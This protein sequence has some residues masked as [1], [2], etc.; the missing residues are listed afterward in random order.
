VGTRDAGREQM[1]RSRYKIV[2]PKLPHFL[3]CTVLYWIP[4]FTRQATVDI[5]L[6]SLQSLMKEGMNL[7]AYVIL[8][9]HL[10]MV[11]QSDVLGRDI[12]RFK[13]FPAKI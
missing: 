10:H 7:Y 8:E 3:T 4:I 2:D 9:N 12:G 11:A 5:V 6:Q 13:S 1:G